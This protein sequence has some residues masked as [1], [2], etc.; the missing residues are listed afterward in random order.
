VPYAYDDAEAEFELECEVCMKSCRVPA[1]FEAESGDKP[2]LQVP[3]GWSML[4][5]QDD[6]GEIT[7]EVGVRCT[8]CHTC[9]IDDKL[10]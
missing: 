3:C 1:T 10:N 8:P 7:G 4:L 6:D 5:I 9:M 2:V